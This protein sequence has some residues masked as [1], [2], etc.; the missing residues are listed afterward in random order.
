MV[1][2][3]DNKLRVLKRKRTLHCGHWT[4]CGLLGS[5]VV[6][7]RS[8]LEKTRVIR[9]DGHHLCQNSDIQRGLFA[10]RDF[11][12]TAALLTDV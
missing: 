2:E 7:A 1:C 6:S 4:D 12:A 10:V 8:N 5:H 3:C 9:P 11:K